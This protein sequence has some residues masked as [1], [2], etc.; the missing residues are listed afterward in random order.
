MMPAQVSTVALAQLAEA[1]D[2]IAATLRVN[3][4]VTDADF[5]A[6][7]LPSQGFATTPAADAAINAALRTVGALESRVAAAAEAVRQAA[8][9][10][11]SSDSRSQRRQ[12]W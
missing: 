9:A 5:D 7:A 4:R 6:V 11:V 12:P 8:A 1:L 10:Y 2:A 3:I